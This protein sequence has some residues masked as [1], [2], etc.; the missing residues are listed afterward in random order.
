MREAQRA[1]PEDL[2]D[3]R[4]VEPCAKRLWRLRYKARSM[5]GCVDD[6]ACRDDAWTY[7][8]GPREQLA[9]LADTFWDVLALP[10]WQREDRLEMLA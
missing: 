8:L 9:V 7:L 6:F 5:R 4:F 1:Y 10:S 3:H 2:P